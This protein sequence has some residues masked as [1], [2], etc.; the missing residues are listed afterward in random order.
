MTSRAFISGCSGTALTSREVRFFARTSPWGLILFA[1]NIESPG[2]ASALIDAF[3]QA[4]GWR[5][6]VLIDQEGGRVQRLRPPHWPAYPPAARYGAL[7]ACDAMAGIEAAR[8]GGRLIGEDLRSLGITID[9]APC[10]DLRFP[11]TH[12][13]IGDRAF[14]AEP[15]TV[16]T[17]ARAQ[18]EGLMEAGVLPVIKH[19]PGHGRATADSHL[20]LPV[21][22]ADADELK[23]TDFMPFR[24]LKDMPVAMTAHIL[25]TALDARRPVSLSAAI[26]GEVIRGEI[27]FAGLLMSDDVSMRALDGPLG[28]RYGALFAA[29]C[30]LALHCNGEMAEM[31]AVAEASPELKGAALERAE[32]ALTHLGDTGPEIETAD[33]RARLDALLAGAGQT[34]ERDENA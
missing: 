14:G 30:D 21:V 1:R 7:Y 8:L 34:D 25:F 18:C 19:I 32:A 22:D 6:P 13:V 17:L 3:R 26:I 4:V 31:E 5:A 27:G 20:E 12:R 29:G 16:A 23:R 9:C 10:L 33:A 28:D 2:Q 11:A 15:E 24:L